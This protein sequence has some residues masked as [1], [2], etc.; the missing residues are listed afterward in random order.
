[1]G[2]LKTYIGSTHLQLKSMICLDKMLLMHL[3]TLCSLAY[4]NYHPMLLL[5]MLIFM[6]VSSIITIIT[7]EK[8]LSVCILDIMHM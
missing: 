7:P 1:M 4:Q 3:M 5:K 2:T 6:L 8:Y